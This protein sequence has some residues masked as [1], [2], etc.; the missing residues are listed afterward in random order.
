MRMSHARPIIVTAS[1]PGDILAFADRLRGAHFPPERNLLAAH[2]T[3][4]H[5][6]PPSCERELRTLLAD[7][8]AETAPLSARL[9]GVISLGQGTALA[10]DSPDLLALRERIA[11]HFTGSLSAQDTHRPRL[12]VTIQNKVTADAA[13]ALQRDLAAQIAP[14]GF[15]IAGLEMHFYDGG[16]WLEAGRWRFRG[17]R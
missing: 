5:A 17:R 7:L 1:L 9:T 10:I 14:R 13:R 6:I 11:E 2:L 15:A 3:L 4:F 16:P 12:H 8:S